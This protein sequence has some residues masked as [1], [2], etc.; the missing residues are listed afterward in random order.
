METIERAV[1]FL[2]RMFSDLVGDMVR[3]MN[4]WAGERGTLDNLFRE[5]RKVKETPVDGDMIA[6]IRRG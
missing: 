3:G 1:V 6:R 4:R 2:H 5:A